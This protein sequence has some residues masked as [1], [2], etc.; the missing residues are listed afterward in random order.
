MTLS[1]NKKAV[2]TKIAE[3]G[4]VELAKDPDYV[5][6]KTKLNLEYGQVLT[7][8]EIEQLIYRTINSSY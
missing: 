5:E 6:L 3:D 7:M 1:T 8:E 4:Y 2:E